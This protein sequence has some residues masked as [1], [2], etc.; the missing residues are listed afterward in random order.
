VVADRG[1]ASRTNRGYFT[2]G[3]GDYIHAEKLRATNREATA[4]LAG[5]GRY[6]S[7][8][9][10]LRVMEVAVASPA[11]T[12][13]EFAGTLKHKPGL[14]PY[15]HRTPKGLLRIDRAAAKREAHRLSRF[16]P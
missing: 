10:N 8:A 1:F 4:A 9:G 6:L 14:R 11:A 12:G 2:Q 7:V 15:L 16:E 5:P 3:G 13:S